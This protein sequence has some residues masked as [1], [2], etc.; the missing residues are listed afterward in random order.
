MRG[1]HPPQPMSFEALQAAGKAQQYG[2][3]IISYSSTLKQGSPRPKNDYAYIREMW[4]LAPPH[5]GTDTLDVSL[6]NEGISDEK[7]CDPGTPPEAHM[8]IR[9][10]LDSDEDNNH[11]YESPGPLR[12]EISP[13]YFELDPKD[14][15]KGSRQITSSRHSLHPNRTGTGAGKVLKNMS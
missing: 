5:P 9:P 12:R 6:Y 15:R 4:P 2:D 13:H 10:T 14:P 8:L 1:S 11:I 3:H 7:F